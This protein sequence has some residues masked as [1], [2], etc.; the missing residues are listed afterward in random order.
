MSKQIKCKCCNRLFE[1]DANYTIYCSHCV[2]INCEDA[3]FHL[4]KGSP[5]TIYTKNIN[6]QNTRT[7][8]VELEVTSKVRN[9]TIKG[10]DRHEPYI[11]IL[12]N[13][14]NCHKELS[15]IKIAGLSLDKY[16]IPRHDG[17][18]DHMKG[19]EFNTV[20]LCNDEGFK[21]LEKILEVMNKYFTVDLKCG[22]HVHLGV[23]DF[24]KDK[25]QSLYVF[26]RYFESYFKYYVRKDR[27]DNVYCKRMFKLSKE[28]IKE[29]NFG[30]YYFVPYRHKY[31]AEYNENRRH[32]VNF[33][34]IKIYGTVEFR[35]MEG[36][37]DYA[38][39]KHWIDLHITIFEWIKNNDSILDT[40]RPALRDILG[41]K[42]WNDLRGRIRKYQKTALKKVIEKPQAITTLNFGIPRFPI[43]MERLNRINGGQ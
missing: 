21:I 41:K 35:V 38:K 29:I 34:P 15:S 32:S 4:F 17:S 27:L 36:T 26:Y 9:H 42:L 6:V 37:L 31:D 19:V 12:D 3:V 30:T 16:L 20:I 33:D 10:M 11:S 5:M 28:K 25:L 7:F 24:T 40:K 22:L 8:G 43:N 18:L 39:I 1:P 23:N 2:G 13:V 14:V